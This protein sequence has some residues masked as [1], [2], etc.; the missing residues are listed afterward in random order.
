MSSDGSSVTATT[1]TNI[2]IVTSGAF[3][4]STT[5]PAVSSITR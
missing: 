1:C 3:G 5:A 4:M 2:V